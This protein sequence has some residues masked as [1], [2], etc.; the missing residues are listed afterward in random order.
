M[1]KS[2]K[3]SFGTQNNKMRHK[4]NVKIGKHAR[5]HN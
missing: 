4:L 1:I 2:K 5:T 3:N